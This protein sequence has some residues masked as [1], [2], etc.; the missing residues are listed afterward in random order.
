MDSGAAES[1]IPRGWLPQVTVT[2][3]EGSKAGLHYVAANG[4][5]IANEGEQ[6]VQFTTA[7]GH[8][9]GMTFQVANVNKP[10]GS[11]KK[12]CNK[13][14]RVVFDNDGSYIENK[15][16][17]AIMMLTEESGVYTLDAWT[18]PAG[19]MRQGA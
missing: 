1:V 2:E 3:S 7:E 15:R 11:V 12:I 17:G 9:A 8:A 4:A 10:L 5:K 19:F 6:K 14:H 18:A 16:T 13:G